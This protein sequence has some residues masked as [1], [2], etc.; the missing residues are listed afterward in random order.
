MVSY[1]LEGKLQG[2][3]GRSGVPSA[4]GDRGSNN[5]LERWAAPFGKPEQVEWVR[6]DVPP[7]H[8][9]AE[10]YLNPHGICWHEAS[11]RLIVADRDHGRIAIVHPETGLEEGNLTCNALQ[12]GLKGKPYGVRTIGNTLFVAVADSP[13]D[14]QNLFVHIV[15]ISTLSTDRRCSKLLQTIAFTASPVDRNDGRVVCN[16]P[17][18]MGVDRETNDVYVAC[19]AEPGSNFVRLTPRGRQDFVI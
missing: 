14:G 17:H 1:S 4:D 16:G 5:R 9:K 6:P 7:S 2:K 18:L 10:E 12:L 11:D 3:A 15:D 13:Q 8:R 19:V